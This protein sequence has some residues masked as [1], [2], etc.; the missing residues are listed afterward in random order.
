MIP[1]DP[2]ISDC[3]QSITNDT[4]KERKGKERKG[5]REDREEVYLW[6]GEGGVNSM[7]YFT[8]CVIIYK[9]ITSNSREK[10]K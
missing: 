7:K 2:S 5:K 9:V 8:F 10:K 1:H 3:V 4:R 6:E